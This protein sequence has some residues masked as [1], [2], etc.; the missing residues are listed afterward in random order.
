M[1]PV[2]IVRNV[3]SLPPHARSLRLPSSPFCPYTPPKDPS[4]SRIRTA[5]ILA[6]G[7]GTRFLPATQAVPTEML[8]LYDRPVIQYILAERRPSGLD[9]TALVTSGAQ[10]P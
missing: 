4:L 9:K 6:A 3:A 8:P 7:F 10:P 2:S 1:L 5:I